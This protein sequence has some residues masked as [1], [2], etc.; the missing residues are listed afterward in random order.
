MA[1]RTDQR[2]EGTGRLLVKGL[3]IGSIAGA[4]YAT[5]K[6]AIEPGPGAHLI[7]EKIPP[8]VL[9]G[10]PR[11]KIARRVQN[12]KDK[13]GL[14][15][16]LF[17]YQTCPFCCKVRAF[18][19]LHG[20]SYNVVEV[21][22]VTKKDLKWSQSK[23][24]PTLLVETSDHKFL[25]LTDSSVIV[26]VLASYLRKPSQ[27]IVELASFYPSLTFYDTRGK[28]VDDTLNKYFLMTGEANDKQR[29]AV[30]R[31]RKW[32]S[33]VD[34]HLVHMISPNVYRSGREAL[35]TFEWFSETGEWDKHFPAWERNM[36]VYVGATAMW[37][38]SKLLKKRYHLTDDVRS[39]I[40]AAC[41]E[42]TK[43]LEQQKTPFLGG[44]KPDLADVSA[45][46]VLNSMEG[47]DAWK[48][49]LANTNIGPW[50]NAMKEL[51]HQ[52]RGQAIKF[53]REDFIGAAV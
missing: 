5:Y 15:I 30:E 36:M 19:D 48:D 50:F 32:R 17:Q 29:E 10:H 43:E 45:F 46:G 39:H 3:L 41:N 37:G 8:K 23:K 22:G 52:N 18:L 6:S 21:D 40:Y 13:S 14:N 42:L 20:I 11:V 34:S 44:K 2:R 26:S 38:I 28:K 27:D 53:G 25:Q 49:C 31:E 7:N 51:V 16:T 1:T 33:W 4:G 47:C 12:E 9:E 24:V 35:Q